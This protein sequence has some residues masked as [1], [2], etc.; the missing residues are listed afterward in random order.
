MHSSC[1]I[2]DFV[3]AHLCSCVLYSGRVYN[4]VRVLIKD[5]GRRVPL[6]I[7]YAFHRIPHVLLWSRLILGL[8]N[9]M[10]SATKTTMREVCGQE[11]VMQGMSYICGENVYVYSSNNEESSHGD[12]SHG[13]GRNFWAKRF[14]Q[15]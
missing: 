15:V 9:G 12:G 6:Y 3:E 10:A 4:R 13:K 7:S 5:I 11:H 14:E 2:E 8:T 1:E